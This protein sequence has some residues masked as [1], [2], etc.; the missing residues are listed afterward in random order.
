MTQYRNGQSDCPQSPTSPLS[1]ASYSPSQSPGLS[2]ANTMNSSTFSDAY[3]VQQQTNAL[4]HRFEH[5]NMVRL[6]SV[7]LFC[8]FSFDQKQ[9]QERFYMEHFLQIWAFLVRRSSGHMVSLC[10]HC[11]P[12][13]RNHWRST[14]IICH[15]TTLGH[16]TKHKQYLFDWIILKAPKL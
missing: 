15:R 3:Y 1:Q 2:P 5:F 12:Y 6:I 7:F 9:I 4:Q 14:F 13:L 10:V 8:F 11:V 16:C